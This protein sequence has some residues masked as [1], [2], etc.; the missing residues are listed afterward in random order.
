MSRSVL[1]LVE[2]VDDLVKRGIRVVFIHNSLDLK[3]LSNPMTTF[4]LHMLAAFAEM[5]R[6]VISQRTKEA[7]RNG[8]G[9]R[10]QVR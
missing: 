3:D 6:N 1:E 8:Q 4:A 7:L 9:K 2:M 5:E 10:W